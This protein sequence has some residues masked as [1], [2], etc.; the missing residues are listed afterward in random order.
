MKRRTLVDLLVAAGLLT[1]GGAGLAWQVSAAHAQP[2]PLVCPLGPH[3]IVTA[4]AKPPRT[5]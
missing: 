1:A 5:P 3:L 4:P 2:P